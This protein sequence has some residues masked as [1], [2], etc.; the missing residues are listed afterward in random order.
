MTFNKLGATLEESVT[1]HHVIDLI[2]G[3]ADLTSDDGAQENVHGPV[4]RPRGA[5]MKDSETSEPRVSLVEVEQQGPVLGTFRRSD[6]PALGNR[7]VGAREVEVQT[8]KKWDARRWE[9][10]ISRFLFHL[11]LPFSLFFPLSWVSSR[12]ILVVFE[13]PGPSN[14][15]VWALGLSC[16][17]PAPREKK[18]REDPQREKKT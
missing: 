3:C 13:A 15:H 11:P 12:G 6:V 14:V 4:R 7:R 8:K 18:T 5:S 1:G 10:Q 2:P 9:F 17:N 16:E